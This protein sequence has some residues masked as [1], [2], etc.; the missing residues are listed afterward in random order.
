MVR[1]AIPIQ[2][3]IDSVSGI[4]DIDLGI[5]F[6]VWNNCIC[7]SI[8]GDAVFLWLGAAISAAVPLLEEFASF[9]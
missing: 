8:L 9:E 3:C 2:K 4:H 6:F 7:L 5:V 1:K